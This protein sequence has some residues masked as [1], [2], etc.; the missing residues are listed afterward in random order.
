LKTKKIVGVYGLTNTFFG[1]VDAGLSQK[2]GKINK[3]EQGPRCLNRSICVSILCFCRNFYP[4]TACLMNLADLM[5]ES[6]QG[7]SLGFHPDGSKS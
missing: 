4:Q 2:C 3:L 1:K 6:N 5:L 7:E